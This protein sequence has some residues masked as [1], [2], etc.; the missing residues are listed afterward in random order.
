MAEITEAKNDKDLLYLTIK[1]PIKNLKVDK[2][3]KKQDKLSNI[4]KNLKGV[5]I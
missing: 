1:I 4:K 2:N 5:K 3:T